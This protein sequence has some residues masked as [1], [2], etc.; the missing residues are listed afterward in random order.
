MSQI[1]DKPRIELMWGLFLC[2][3]LV[4]W[5]VFF[6][7]VSE[8]QIVNLLFFVENRRQYRRVASR[9][10]PYFCPDGDK[11]KQKRL[12]PSGGHIPLPALLVF[13]K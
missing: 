5:F 9:Q 10:T 2:V 8:Q 12:A 4:K 1:V 3:W 6:S 13:Y 7:A 11:S